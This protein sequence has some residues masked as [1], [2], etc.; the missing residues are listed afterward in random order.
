MRKIER[1]DKATKMVD[2]HIAK[3]NNILA[4][5][6]AYQNYGKLKA[7]T[8]LIKEFVTGKN[9]YTKLFKEKESVVSEKV[10]NRDMPGQRDSQVEK[11]I[12]DSY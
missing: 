8:S 9:S 5:S 6:G 1:I 12:R 11:V 2:F 3:R 7:A 4:K 10:K